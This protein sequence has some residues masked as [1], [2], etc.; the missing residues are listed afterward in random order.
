M[1]EFLLS[2][3][4]IFQPESRKIKSFL[5]LFSS[6]INIYLNSCQVSQSSRQPQCL[7][8]VHNFPVSP[9]ST[10]LLVQFSAP[11]DFLSKFLEGSGKANALPQG[12]SPHTASAKKLPGETLNGG[13]VSALQKIDTSAKEVKQYPRTN[14]CFKGGKL[15]DQGES[16]QR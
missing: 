2:C 15:R 7:L 3:C 11:L 5:A 16:K 10:H 13:L 12:S 8:L 14:F 1:I 4:G 6:V 9:L